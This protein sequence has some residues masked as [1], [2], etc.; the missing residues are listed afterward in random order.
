M[1]WYIRG[2]MAAIGLS[3]LFI[4]GGFL[5]DGSVLGI[6][7]GLWVILTSGVIL[8]AGVGCER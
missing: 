1:T 6:I 2:F 8:L 4:G 5:L 3:G 7:S